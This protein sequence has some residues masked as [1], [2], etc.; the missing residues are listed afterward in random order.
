MTSAEVSSTRTFTLP[1]FVGDKHSPLPEHSRSRSWKQVRDPIKV[2]TWSR[3]TQVHLG[4]IRWSQ[5]RS[6][7]ILLHLGPD[8]HLN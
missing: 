4:L 3:I 2:W 5:W 7:S 6:L 8:G 1:S